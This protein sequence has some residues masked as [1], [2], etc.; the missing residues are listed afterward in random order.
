MRP[1]KVEQNNGVVK[2]TPDLAQK[3]RKSSSEVLILLPNVSRIEA[4][5]INVMISMTA[6]G[7]SCQG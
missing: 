3:T 7:L 1:G 5:S 4:Q 6:N 2:R